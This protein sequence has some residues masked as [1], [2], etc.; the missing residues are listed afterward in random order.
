[1]GRERG[2]LRWT[3]EGGGV[4]AESLYLR[5][6]EYVPLLLLIPFTL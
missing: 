5:E 6:V 3:V 2:M 1:M 4:A